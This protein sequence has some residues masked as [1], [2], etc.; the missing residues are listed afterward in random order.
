MDV[1]KISQKQEKSVAKDLNAR[2]VV[3]S[4]ALWNAKADVRNSQFLV[5]CKTTSKD[6]YTITAKVWEKICKEANRDR[7]REPLL[8]ID[9]HNNHKERYVCFPF[10]IIPFDLDGSTKT[11]LWLRGNLVSVSA[12]AKQFRF[13]G[14]SKHHATTVTFYSSDKKRY[15]TIVL[16][17]FKDFERFCN[18]VL[19][20][21]E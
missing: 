10:N 4:G 13:F 18:E 14:V 6:Y 11:P 20:K 7:M 8:V 17:R 3:A 19:F 12:N 2:T 16:M 1:R 5:E 15:N 21:E 9:L